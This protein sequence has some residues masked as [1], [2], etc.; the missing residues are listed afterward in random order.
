LIRFRANVVKSVIRVA[1]VSCRQIQFSHPEIKRKDVSPGV[2][3]DGE[4]RVFGFNMR[5][6]TFAKA[7][8]FRERILKPRRPQ[9]LD[10]FQLFRGKF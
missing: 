6:D 1:G 5:N 2:I 10:K 8:N 3:P 9:K 7:G 4:T